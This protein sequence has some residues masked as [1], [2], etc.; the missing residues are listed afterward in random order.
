[1]DNYVVIGNPVS[2]SKSPFIHT[3]FARQTGQQMHYQT[4][5]APLDGFASTAAHF[6]ANGG[7]GCN[8]TLPFKEQAFVFAKQ[9]T[10][11][12]QLAGAVNT[13]KRLDDG[14]ILGDNTDGYG[15][16]QDL[17]N[18]HVS[19]EKSS[20]LLLGAGGGARGVLFD[21]LQQQPKR[22]VIANRCAPK[23]ARL[24][25]D[26]T[27]WAGCAQLECAK[28]QDVSQPFDLVINATAASLNGVLPA[29]SAKIIGPRTLVYDMAYGQG[30]TV[31]NQWAKECG[32]LFTMDGLGM[33]VAQAAESFTV[34]R[35]IRPSA[36]Q[37][38]RELRR[39][40]SS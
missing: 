28:L 22:L 23:A 27:A 9:L 33:L 7:R 5:E 19:L 25:S 13:L 12:A 39:S 30:V 35:G 29:V 14:G 40:L 34:W 2:H 32:A 15:L 4:L 3:L 17:K 20:I 6:F 1:M 11:R 8:V 10:K 18:H 38:L 21:L 37:V 16:I 31:F 26:F 24:V 36:T